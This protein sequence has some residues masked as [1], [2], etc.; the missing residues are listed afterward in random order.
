MSQ[1]ITTSPARRLLPRFAL[2]MLTATPG[3]MDVLQNQPG[4]IQSMICRHACGD[5]G[6]LE[7]EDKEANEQAVQQGGRILS[8]YIERETK[9]YVITSSERTDTCILLPSE[10]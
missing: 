7:E 9:F 10:Y 5:W 6:I 2:G 8:V 1:E 3:A 4:L